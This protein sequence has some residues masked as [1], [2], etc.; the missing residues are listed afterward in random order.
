[1]PLPYLSEFSGVSCQVKMP[2]ASMTC[3]YIPRTMQTS[4]IYTVV[5]KITVNPLMH[6]PDRVLGLT[7]L[8][9]NHKIPSIKLR[10]VV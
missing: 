9:T 10:F 5:R 4:Q 3:N 8:D 6:A 2:A 7:A 1:M